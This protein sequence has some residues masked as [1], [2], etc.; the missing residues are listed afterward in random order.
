MKKAV[1]F[2]RDGTLIH[3]KHYLND[4]NNI[5]YMPGVFTALKSLSEAGYL[6]FVV[7]NQSGIPRGLVSEENLQEIHQHMQ[8]EFSKHG[9][10]IEKYYHSPYLP[11]SDHPSRKP[12]PGMLLQAAEEF[13]IDLSSSWMIGDKDIDLQAGERAGT[14]SLQVSESKSLT[15]CANEIL[16]ANTN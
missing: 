16:K 13:S 15:D 1:F 2:D 8:N 9:F 14:H 6:L 3:D 11:E 7:T 10:K 12:N 4:P 5:D